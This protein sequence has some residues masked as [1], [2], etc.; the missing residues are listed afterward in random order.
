MAERKFNMDQT[1]TENTLSRNR[2][3]DLEK[4]YKDE[5][6]DGTRVDA[7]DAVE[8][9]LAKVKK[10]GK[11]SITDQLQAYRLACL[12]FEVTRKYTDRFERASLIHSPCLSYF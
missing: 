4:E 1:R 7:I 5:F 8:A 6:R 2:Q 12:I 9:K 10:K 3:S 11:P